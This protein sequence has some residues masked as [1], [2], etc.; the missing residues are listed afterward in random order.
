[1]TRLTYGRRD[2]LLGAVLVSA[3]SSGCD[4]KALEFAKNTAVILQQRSDQL[5]TKITAETKAYNSAA[6]TA[7]EVHRDLA[8]SALRNERNSRTIALA[9]DYDEGRKPVSRWRSD[10]AEYG[11]IDYT[12]TRELL[13]A[14]LDASSL[15]LQKLQALKIEQDKVDALAKLLEAL[16]N[17]PS[18]SQDVAALG[19]F[20][21]DTKTEF[22]KKV[23]AELAKD[24][25]AA[26]KAAF[27]AKGCSK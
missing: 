21:Q 17:K 6:A 10:V 19:S 13:I 26:G 1:M 16:A 4:D 20:A 18:L 8:D 12:T 11:Q 23:C 24:T 3:L 27:A 14:D 25:S 15:F 2:V 5:S 22:D 7:A 9:A